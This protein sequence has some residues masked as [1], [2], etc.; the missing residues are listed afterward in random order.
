MIRVGPAGWSYKDW[1]GIVYPR[2][3]KIDQLKY[4]SGFFDTIEIN[5]TFYRPPS[6]RSAED[7]LRRVEENRNFRFTVKLWQNFT[8]E[9][10]QLVPAEIKEWKEGVL[11]LREAQRLGAILVQ[12]PLSFKNTDEARRHLTSVLE[13]FSE[14]PLVV[15]FRHRSWKEPALLKFLRQLKIGICNIDQPLIGKGIKPDTQVTSRLGYFRCHGRNYREW[16]RKEAG[17]DARYDYLYKTEELDEQTELVKAIDEQ[18]EETYAI[19]NNHYRGQA[20]VN[21]LQLRRRIEGKPP[22]VPGCL[23]EAYPELRDELQGPG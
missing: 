7:W 13:A 3:A 15:E 9:R 8:H 10:G 19:Y 21:A 5:N 1:E 16:F 12:F 2:K 22:P 23:I 6:F 4:L 18:A 20:A 11:P 14:F 17:R